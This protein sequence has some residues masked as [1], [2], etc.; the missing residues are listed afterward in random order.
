MWI[1]R[2]Q[3]TKY[4]KTTFFFGVI[5]CYLLY[6]VSGWG[7]TL[8]DVKITV[9][10]SAA[11]ATVSTSFPYLK[12]NKD[13]ALVLQADDATTDVYDSVYPFF[14]G[15]N[16][17]PGLFFTD[18]TGNDV[19]FSL[20]VNYFSLKSGV[21]VHSDDTANYLSWKKIDELWKNGYSID[22]RGLVDPPYGSDQD[23]QVQRN[24]SFAVKMTAPYTNGGI[25]TDTYVLP[26]DGQGQMLP[27]R[28]VGYIAFFSNP[29]F[30]LT[31]NPIDL[32][33]V[34]PLFSPP[35]LFLTNRL[36]N[37]LYSKVQLMDL[38]SI[39]GH[40]YMGVYDFR[41]FGV[42]P[43]IS[44]SEF[45]KEMEEIASTYGKNG[46]DNIW[47]A[48]DQEVFEYLL[49][50]EKTTISATTLGNETQIGFVGDQIP[51]NMHWYTLT[52]LVVGD[53]P[54][55]SVDVQGAVSS[56]HAIHGDTAIINFSWDGRIIEPEGERAEKYIQI[57][58]ND[59][60][61]ANCLIASDYVD[62]IQ[63]P[64]TLQ[65]Y[66]DELCALNTSSLE[67][68]C[69]YHFTVS[70]DT[71]CL[72]D[73]ATLQA[74]DGMKH[75]LWNTGDTVQTI[76]IAPKENTQ[77]WVEITTP[78]DQ[79]G[80]DTTQVIV[81]PVP[82]FQHSSDSVVIQPGTDT[83]LW[84]SGGYPEYLWSTGA[85]DTS[86]RVQPV[87]NTTYWV[88]V[89]N[90]YG[91]STTQDFMVLP[92]YGYVIDFKY[93]TVCLGDSTLLINQS[94]SEKD[95][96]LQTA[97]DLNMDG[98]Y[99][100]AFG[101][102]VLYAFPK[103]QLWLVGM[104]LTFK[105]GNIITKVH[106]VPVGEVPQV[107]FSYSGQCSS[108]GNTLFIDSTKVDFGDIV[109]RYWDYG[110]GLSEYRPNMYAYHQYYP[111]NYTAKLVVTTS[112]GCVDSLSKPISI[113]GSPDI[114][115][116]REDGTQVYY[117]DTVSFAQGDS[118]YL[119]VKDPEDYDSIVWP[120][121]VLS[122]DY[123]VKEEGEYTVKAYVNICPGTSVFYAVYTNSGG[124]DVPVTSAPAM[125]FFTPNGDG[126][127]D[128]WKVDNTKVIPP[129]SL[130]VYNRAG[131]LVYSSENYNNDWKGDFNGNPL[132]KGTYYY[133]I[134]D[135]NGKEY[136][137]TISIIR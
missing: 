5:L 46:K 11:P 33:S 13:F 92:D 55:S 29:S 89:T 30:D 130:R 67:N 34:K 88:K 49:L 26:S 54:V 4:L 84:A 39:N 63:N 113:Y 81:Y 96:L 80:R 118:A 124:G 108:E 17:N 8:E 66:H 14:S 20:D 115:I 62:A 86:I 61:A 48:G 1:V 16:G 121:H 111:G 107:D 59:T 134:V 106:Q 38:Q 41:Q 51:T 78:D 42:S 18:G 73:T 110:D 71:I 120:P 77:Y 28:D 21:D 101:D 74:P 27:A 132:P 103:A 31:N 40:H 56:T 93:D 35:R 102:T 19:P 87:R 22:S 53:Q 6:P 65:K 25:T 137:G 125:P 94:S 68:Y 129:F 79:T 135:H 15:K 91:C 70:P 9:T 10:F 99:D 117:N 58:K 85:T 105:S 131:S 122:P 136:R 126:Y 95:T 23:Y 82:V 119:T 97:W 98:E 90:S 76:K 64:D 127:N 43:D 114:V 112:Y 2:S 50:C 109:T 83:L 100:D 104:R 7:Q 36:D 45:K 75:Y 24:I 128:V 133:V 116:L 72:G 52:L 3:K 60:S 69:S 12:Y 32:T 44:F 47:V 123:Y 37:S 57:A